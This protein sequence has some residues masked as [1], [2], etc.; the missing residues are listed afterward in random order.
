[1]EFCKPPLKV[2]DQIALLQ[3]RGMAIAD[4]DRATRVLQ[5]IN[6]YRLRAYWLPFEVPEEKRPALGEHFFKNGTDF[7]QVVSVR[8]DH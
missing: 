3:K 6:Y 4:E 2:S 7:D 5:H 8:T 1:M